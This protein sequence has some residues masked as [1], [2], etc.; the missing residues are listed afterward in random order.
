MTDRLLLL[1]AALT[2][3]ACGGQRET[4]CCQHGAREGSMTPTT[5]RERRLAA[6]EIADAV[7]RAGRTA[8]YVAAGAAE[9][10]ARAALVPALLAAARG[11]AVD[12]SRLTSLA[13]VAGMTLERWRVDA[14]TYYAVIEPAARGAGAYFVRLSPAA[15]AGEGEVLLEAPHAYFD[16]GTG[17]IAARLFFT[18][19]DWPPPR[20]FF[21]N[22]VHRFR[23]SPEVRV[24]TGDSPSDVCH[25]PDHQFTTATV[26]FARATARAR[27]I[28]L[29]GF[30]DRSDQE[31]EDDREG[32]DPRDGERGRDAGGDRA[33]R[34]V[35]AAPSAV[36]SAGDRRGSSPL[37]AAIAAGLDAALG[38]VA[39]YPET[40]H[41]LGG[42]T[43]VLV[44]A[45]AR[46]PGARFV[47]VELSSQLRRRLRDPAPIAD[48][49][50]PLLA[51]D[52][53]GLAE[54]PP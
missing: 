50:R 45:L 32:E 52:G 38:G 7:W 42:T 26:A 10:E 17:E 1:L 11:G 2:A 5:I 13:E 40:S 21:T 51:E 53:A 18:A 28:Q 8:H 46:V 24:Q 31:G 27:V 23:P 29:H 3:T 35:A 39:R 49:A 37:S 16:K 9:H 54:A 25:N 22:T 36:V 6:T 30:A 12:A 48:F 15:A 44:L 19:G 20:A 34:T 4:S 14:A 47:H 41:E 43:N 33:R